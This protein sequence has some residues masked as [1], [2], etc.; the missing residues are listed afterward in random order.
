MSGPFLLLRA[1]QDPALCLGFGRAFLSFGLCFPS[2][3]QPERSLQPLPAILAL[4]LCLPPSRATELLLKLR[5]KQELTD[6]VFSVLENHGVTL[7]WP[8]CAAEI[9]SSTHVQAAQ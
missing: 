9:V 7:F 2:S 6:K 3:V 1:E 4:P 5:G 8:G